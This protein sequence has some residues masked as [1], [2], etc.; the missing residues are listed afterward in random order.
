MSDRRSYAQTRVPSFSPSTNWKRTEKNIIDVSFFEF[1]CPHWIILLNWLLLFGYPF[2]FP[3]EL[4]VILVKFWLDRNSTNLFLLY[5][6]SNAFRKSSLSYCS[7]QWPKEKKIQ[8][9]KHRSTKN[10]YKT[11]HRVTRTPLKTERELRERVRSSCST[12]D[13]RR[14]NHPV[15]NPVIS[16]ERGQEYLHILII[17]HRQIIIHI[18]KN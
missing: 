4:S 14:V 18:G 10:T 2:F 3:S 5:I 13:T 1:F 17:Y 12:S 7:T 8:K 11:K 9:D 15:T 6:N 16:H